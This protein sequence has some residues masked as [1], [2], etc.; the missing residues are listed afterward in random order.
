MAQT[1]PNPWERGPLYGDL[2]RLTKQQAREVLKTHGVGDGDYH[3]PHCDDLHAFYQYV[4]RPVHCPE[5]KTI[6][7]AD[8]VAYLL[9]IGRHRA[10]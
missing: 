8:V 10:R 6:A 9:E 2:E 1:H 3:D 4:W 5:T 7:R